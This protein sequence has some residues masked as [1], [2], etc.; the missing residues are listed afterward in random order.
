MPFGPL[1]PAILLTQFQRLQ[2]NP[3][4]PPRA[5]IH[6]APDRTC[7]L[8]HVSVALDVDY[9]NKTFTGHV[10]NTLSPL[11]SG[12]TEVMLNAGEA[13]DLKNVTVDGASARFRRDKEDL[14]VTV[15]KTVRGRVLKIAMDYAAA[16]SAGR[17]F[18]AG[19]GAGGGFHWIVPGNTGNKDR[20]GFWTQ[21]ET[22][23]NRQW[24]PTWDY[25]N[26]LTT[27]DE[28]YT[29]PAD[30]TA[31]GNGKLVSEK[32]NPGGKTKTFVWKQEI[33]QATYLFTAVG[34]PFDVKKDVWR[35]VPLWYVVPKGEAKYIDASFGDTPDMLSF[36]S[37]TFG[38][39]YPWAKYAQNAMYDFGGGMENASATTLQES[40]LTDGKDGF[41]SMASLN[42][43][44]LGHQWFGDTVTCQDWGNIFNN[45]SFATPAPDALLRTL[46]RRGRLPLGGR[47]QPAPVP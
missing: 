19:G 40:A 39:K 29:V 42:S 3:F 25:P 22:E 5:S 47:G 6:Y 7:D 32:A 30:W 44:E 28:T 10:V 33:P 11:R 37:D 2:G 45:E 41:R 38:Y 43:H 35:G 20:V 17:S 1:L 26:D 31:I 21:G 34:G 13:L 8:T 24:C 46:A 23:S 12:L 36:Y 27:V 9:P 15:P 14:F 16:N 4:V 18:G